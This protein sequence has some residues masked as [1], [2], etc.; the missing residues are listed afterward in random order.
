MHIYFIPKRKRDAQAQCTF[1][2]ISW[3]QNDTRKNKCKTNHKSYV[4]INPKT[5][6][7]IEELLNNTTIKDGY[8]QCCRNVLKYIIEQVLRLGDTILDRLQ[9]D[10]PAV[11]R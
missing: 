11:E 7:T 4:T 1:I 3:L 9:N 5:A 6:F 2:Q 8:E 10:F